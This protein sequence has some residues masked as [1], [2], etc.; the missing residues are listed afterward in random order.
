MI[1]KHE[2]SVELEDDSIASKRQSSATNLP[3]DMAA[4]NVLS[5]D[6]ESL[7]PQNKKPRRDG[8]EA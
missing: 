6:W 3:N 2:T 5:H 4:I 8:A 7:K 1:S